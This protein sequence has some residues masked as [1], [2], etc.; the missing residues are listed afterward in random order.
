MYF[1]FI[2]PLFMYDYIQKHKTMIIKQCQWAHNVE[3]YKLWQ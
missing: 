1:Q 3:R 2:T